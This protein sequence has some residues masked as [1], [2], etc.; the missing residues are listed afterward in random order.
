M[1][2]WVK[3]NLDVINSPVMESA[4]NI[5]MPTARMQLWRRAAAVAMTVTVRRAMA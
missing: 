1:R 2:G 3:V 4:G 5:G